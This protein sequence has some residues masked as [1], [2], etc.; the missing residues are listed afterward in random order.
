MDYE[1]NIEVFYDGDCPVC[2]W[3]ITFYERLDKNAHI[4]WTNILDLATSDL[5][6]GKTATDLLGKF[7]VR[8]LPAQPDQHWHIGVDAF[9]RIWRELP[10]F[11]YFAWL[12][13]VPGIRQLAQ[14]AYLGFIRWQASQREKRLK[15]TILPQHKGE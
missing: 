13:S 12:F 14:L 2:R 5:P 1:P 4:R 11:K 10:F 9:A 3:E 15:T 8:N 6:S 7:H